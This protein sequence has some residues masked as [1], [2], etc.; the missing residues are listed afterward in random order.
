MLQLDASVTHVI[1]TKAIPID[2]CI[3]TALLP[4]HQRR[5]LH[6]SVSPSSTRTA[7]QVAH[8][9]NHV[10]NHNTVIRLVHLSH[11]QE[12]Y[13]SSSQSS[14]DPTSPQPKHRPQSSVRIAAIPIRI[15]PKLPI[16]FCQRNP[17]T[18][19]KARPPRPMMLPTRCT[20]LSTFR[21][22]LNSALTYSS[23]STLISCG[24]CFL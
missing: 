23:P 7:E 6:A 21:C 15:Q 1:Q 11:S 19:T 9:S 12:T 4:R 22:A 24:R 14:P 8:L 10:S 13:H 20:G 3:M 5:P 16:T 2:A 18:S 17:P